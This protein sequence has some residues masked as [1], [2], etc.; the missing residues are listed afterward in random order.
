MGRYTGPICRLCRREGM[1]LCD[2]HKCATLKRNFPPGM[3][4][5]SSHG[6]PSGYS[7]QLREKQKC[8]RIFGISEKQMVKYYKQAI[9]SDEESGTK[10]IEQMERRLDNVI[11]RAGFASSRRQARQFVAHGLFASTDTG[12]RVTIPSI[13]V[14]EGDSFTLRQKNR[15]MPAF[16]N[17]AK[18]QSAKWLSADAGNF[19]V[20]VIGKPERTD[21]EGAVDPQVI[22]EFYSR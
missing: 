11:F 3:H 19:T 18:A 12:R 13:Q 8:R 2:K 17:I 15:G 21:M 20:K 9:K 4:G 16:A 22:I 6:K 14:K 5:K 10:L 7:K 1:K